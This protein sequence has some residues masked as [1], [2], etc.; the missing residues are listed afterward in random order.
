MQTASE[1]FP[2]DDCVLSLIRDCGLRVRRRIA[3]TACLGFV[4]NIAR[5]NFSDVFTRSSHLAH[6]TQ[7]KSARCNAGDI[8]GCC[9][10]DIHFKLRQLLYMQVWYG[11]PSHASAAL[12][13]AMQDALPDLFQASPD[14]MYQL[15]TMVSP[16]N[17]KVTKGMKPL[18]AQSTC[19]HQ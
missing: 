5:Q 12:E 15:V 4:L 6:Q 16:L 13:E 9:A 11:V 2:A 14:L 18:K 19:S 17:L 3:K 8:L 1:T 7:L 10:I